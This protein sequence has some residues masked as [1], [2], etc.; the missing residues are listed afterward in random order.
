MYAISGAPSQPDA[1]EQTKPRDIEGA[2]HRAVT[3]TQ[4]S[5][6]LQGHEITNKDAFDLW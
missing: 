1:L 5:Q 3:K 6:G 2:S 4:A